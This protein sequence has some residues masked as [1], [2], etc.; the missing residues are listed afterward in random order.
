[1]RIR[2]DSLFL[3]LT[4]VYLGDI[5][6]RA[7]G[8]S[9]GTF[10]RSRWNLFDGLTVLGSLI[11]TLIVM[12]IGQMDGSASQQAAGSAQKVGDLIHLCIQDTHFA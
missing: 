10:I 5:A 11:T 2:L 6:V 1:M 9:L 8:L 3:V 4:I 12:V 7:Y